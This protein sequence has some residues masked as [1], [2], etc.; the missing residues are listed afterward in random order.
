MDLRAYSDNTL[1]V[2]VLQS[3]LADVG[4][5]ARDFFG[6]ELGIAR[7]RLM[8]LYVNGREHVLL[9][10]VFAYENGVLI[11]VALPGHEAYQDVSAERKLARA[12]RRTVGDYVA[13]LY[14]LSHVD[15]RTLIYAGAL[16]AAQEFFERIRMDKTVSVPHLDFVGGNAV[17]HAVLL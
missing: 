13:R 2:E 12:C 17:D 4:N 9:D 8:L 15:N 16:I 3:V 1:L 6:T 7:F 5:I 11:V 10:E 14:D